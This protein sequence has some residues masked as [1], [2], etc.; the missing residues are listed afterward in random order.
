MALEKI[1]AWH[2]AEMDGENMQAF[3]LA[4]IEDYKS[5]GDRG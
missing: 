4:Q 1:V 5:V 3:S 2:K